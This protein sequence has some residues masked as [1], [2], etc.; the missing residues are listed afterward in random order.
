MSSRAAVPVPRSR[1]RRVE[2]R[3]DTFTLPTDEMRQAM[4]SAELGD[5]V[6]GEDPTV[7]ELETTAARILGKEAGCFMPS[8]TMANLAAIMA[9]C[10]RGAKV[11]VGADSDIYRYEAGGATVCGG[12][13]YH[14]IPNR[15]DGGLDPE[16]ILAAFPDDPGD[17]QF[18]TPRLLCLENPQNHSGGKIL[19]MAYLRE[20]SEL[21]R[22]TGLA[23]HLDGARIFNAAVS[24]GTPADRI[25]AHADSV[26]FCLS[27]GLG[28]PVGSVVAGRAGFVARVRRIRKMLGGGMRQSGVLAAAGLVALRNRDRLA[29]DH[30]NARRLADGLAAIPGVEVDPRQVVMNTVFFRVPGMEHDLFITAAGE[31]GVALAELGH[32]RIRAV[33]HHGVGPDDVDYAIEVVGSLVGSLVGSAAGSAAGSV[34]GSVAVSSGTTVRAADES[35]EVTAEGE[36]PAAMTKPSLS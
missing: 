35:A 5:D 31:R 22:R 8:G 24:S 29:H 32:G 9:H 27:K 12:V 26:Q 18:A 3:S 13:I 2:L 7:R 19:P 36:S 16:L 1:Q 10:P 28:A 21:A 4:V 34:V 14:P 15:S 20:V 30:D 11:I 6:Y 17:P 33:T 25:A 23:V